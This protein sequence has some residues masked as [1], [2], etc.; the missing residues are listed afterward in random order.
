MNFTNNEKRRNENLCFP[1]MST[2]NVYSYLIMSKYYNYLD[3]T[4]QSCHQQ[5]ECLRYL[6][7]YHD[8]NWYLDSW[9]IF[10]FCDT[11][12]TFLK[13]TEKIQLNIQIFLLEVSAIVDIMFQQQINSLIC[14]LNDIRVLIFLS[15]TDLKFLH[16]DFKICYKCS[17][18]IAKKER[19]QP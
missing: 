4:I 16:I 10:S 7:L 11:G 19:N 6:F 15:Y 8:K 2:V 18:E 13:M 1:H 3:L 12:K 14:K 17:D 5:I 9:K